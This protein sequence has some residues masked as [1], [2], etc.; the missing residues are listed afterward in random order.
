MIPPV[1]PQL[2]SLWHTVSPM[3]TPISSGVAGPFLPFYRTPEAG[4]AISGRAAEGTHSPKRAAQNLLLLSLLWGTGSHPA[5]CLPW[6]NAASSHMF[7][8]CDLT[9]FHAGLPGPGLCPV[10]QAQMSQSS[11]D[12]GISDSLSLSPP[13]QH[14]FLKV[15][16]DT[17]R[18]QSKKNEVSPSCI[19]AALRHYGWQHAL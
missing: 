9:C 15:T 2:G 14:R 13:E 1:P 8:V 19:S 17:R 4:L 18:L 10:P 16:Y 11:H 6:P 12:V 7:G 3:S 5:S